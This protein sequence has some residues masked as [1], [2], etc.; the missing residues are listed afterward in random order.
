MNPPAA[1]ADRTKLMPVKTLLT[2]TEGTALP[3]ES[4]SMSDALPLAGFQVISH[5]RFW[6]ITEGEPE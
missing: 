1:G 3:S 5:G 6:V 4:T 2:S